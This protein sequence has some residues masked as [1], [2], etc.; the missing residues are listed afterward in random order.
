MPKISIGVPVYNGASLL[1]ESLDNLRA[2]TIGDFEVIL[3]NNG[4]D[5]GTTE[6]CEEFVMLDPRFSHF[7][8]EE[9]VEAAENF[10][11]V[12]DLANSPL[13]LW[14]AYDDLSDTN[15]L[16]ELSALHDQRPETLLAVGNVSRTGSPGTKARTWL[17]PNIDDAAYLQR[18][19]VQMFRGSASWYYGMWKHSAVVEVTNRIK[20]DYPEAWGMDQLAVYACALKDGVRGSRS[21]TFYQRIFKTVRAEQ[22]WFSPVY[23]EMKARNGRFRTI[24]EALLA[25]SDTSPHSKQVLKV[26]MPSYVRRRCHPAR[27]LLKAALRDLTKTPS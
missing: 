18:L 1:R 2:Q 21:T 7:R 17:Y 10:F 12:R 13:F 27:R 8:R 14:R 9:T 5:D 24:S 22:S 3:A 26:L 11:Y 6:I 19:L 4:S 23:S 20:S 16:E 25:E 15:Y